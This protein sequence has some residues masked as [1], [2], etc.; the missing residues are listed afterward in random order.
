MK[1]STAAALAAGLVLLFAL[2]LA[3]AFV[4]GDHELARQLSGVLANIV[5]AIASFY[6]GSSVGSQQKDATIAAALNAPPPAPVQSTDPQ[7]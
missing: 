5:I 1:I 3:A 7:P 4:T 6:F 2:V